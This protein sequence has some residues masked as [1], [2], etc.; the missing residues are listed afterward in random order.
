MKK[1]FKRKTIGRI[2]A[3]AV[4]GMF[5]MVILSPLLSALT[6]GTGGSDQDSY[7]ILIDTNNNSET[8]VFAVLKDHTSPA[9]ATEL[10][11]VQEDGRVGIGTTSPNNELHIDSSG[12]SCW[13][14]ITTSETGSTTTDGFKFGV[15]ATTKDVYLLNFESTDM[16]FRTNNNNRM[17][18]KSDGKVGIGTSSPTAKA[19]IVQTDAADA[20]RVDDVASDSTPF[21]IDQSGNVGIGTTNPQTKLHIASG[22]EPEFRYDTSI[23]LDKDSVVGY[24]RI[25]ISGT[26]Y[27][28]KVYT[29][30]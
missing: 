6:W 22:N 10:F 11:R 20:L 30:P 13:A 17:I 14:Q 21:V 9:S 24:I 16:Y 27:Y 26:T 3:L 5:G 25:S 4:L 15:Q 23:Y 8:E 29:D 19:H 12:T 18:I 2:F 1:E 28:L 7:P